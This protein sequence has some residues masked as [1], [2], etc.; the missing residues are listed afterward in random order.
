MGEQGDRKSPEA[1]SE[2]LKKS[3]MTKKTSNGIIETI[4]GFVMERSYRH[5]A[6]L[7][8]LRIANQ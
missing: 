5:M 8:C 3:T 2:S 6:H 1:S 7:S 4:G